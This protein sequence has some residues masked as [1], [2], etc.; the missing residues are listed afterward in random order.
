MG[1]HITDE[2]L[3]NAI[4]STGTQKE[5]SELLGISE[6]TVCNRIQKESFKTLLFTY[7]RDLF[8]VTSNRIVSSSKK[9]LETLVA[10]LD[11]DSEMVRYNT[12]TK[13]LSLGQQYVASQDIL[14]RIDNVVMYERTGTK[15]Y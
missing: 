9:A 11:S 5:A 3:L 7:R 4:M 2:E 8:D 13:I 14:K 15:M 1:K 12:A 10:L 6:Q